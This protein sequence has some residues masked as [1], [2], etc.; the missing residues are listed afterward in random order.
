[1][2]Q[3]VHRIRQLMCPSG[4]HSDLQSHFSIVKPC[5]SIS[6]LPGS[7]QPEACA[8]NR[9]SIFGSFES[10][11]HPYLCCC[12]FSYRNPDAYHTAYCISGMSAAQ[13]HM[14][15]S[16]TRREEVRAAWEGE[17]G[18]RTAVFA[19]ALCWTEEDGGS[20]VVGSA[21]NGVVRHFLPL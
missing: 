3:M 8:T 17:D 11:L 9:Q 12:C 15:P 6:S 5:R 7:I 18:V 19:E 1:M 2:T 16:P 4:A 20:H 14:Y 21:A 13:H 10:K